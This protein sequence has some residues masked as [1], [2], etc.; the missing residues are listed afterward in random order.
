MVET[1][2]SGHYRQGADTH[3]VQGQSGDRR[4][5]LIQY[6]ALAPPTGFDAPGN[7][8]T[9]L[10]NITQVARQFGHILSVAAPALEKPAQLSPLFLQSFDG[11]GTR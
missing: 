5:A 10:T 2:M 4:L 7:L 6:E 3:A 1:Y 9:A 8:L 11:L